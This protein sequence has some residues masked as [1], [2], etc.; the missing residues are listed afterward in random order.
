CHSLWSQQGHG[1]LRPAVAIESAAQSGH[2]NN[3]WDEW[4]PTLLQLHDRQSRRFNI[5]RGATVQVTAGPKATLNRGQ[6]ILHTPTQSIGP[7]VFNEVKRPSRLEHP[8]HL[9]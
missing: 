8:P 3:Q 6:Y 2:T 4:Q 1:N 5:L 9:G 7:Y